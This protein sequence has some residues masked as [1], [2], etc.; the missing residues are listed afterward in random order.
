MS[1]MRLVNPGK[2]VL[3][4]KMRLYNPEFD[5]DVLKARSDDTYWQEVLLEYNMYLM[6]TYRKSQPKFYA[7]TVT[8]GSVQ[9]PR[10]LIARVQTLVDEIPAVSEVFGNIELTKAGLPH[11]H[12]T[13]KATNYVNKI[14]L[15]N[16]LKE[17]F[18]IKK[19]TSSGWDKYCNKDVDD[20]QLLTY[21]K[22]YSISPKFHLRKTS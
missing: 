21:L 7:L 8:T 15:K 6:K 3:I 13:L 14:M 4:E 2:K 20:E 12:C 19:K 1:M 9:D 5:F 11:I 17:F 10:I 22:K 18:V 16:R